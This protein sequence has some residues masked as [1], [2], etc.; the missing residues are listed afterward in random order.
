[1][2]LINIT[3]ERLHG[4]SY[5][6]SH[7]LQVFD[8]EVH[9]NFEKLN[10]P[11]TWLRKNFR[12][13]HDKGKEEWRDFFST[14]C[15]LLWQRRNARI[16]ENVIT[17]NETI[18]FKE[19]SILSSLSKARSFLKGVNFNNNIVQPIFVAWAPPRHG[20]VK[21]NVDGACSHNHVG[22]CGGVLRDDQCALK[23]AEIPWSSLNP[24]VFAL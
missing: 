5:Q 1:M 17:S 18:R 19:D 6:Y 24:L 14:V 7:E 15:W 16:F 11:E 4:I 3:G 12:I 20:W 22:A 9:W 10:I 2:F 21:M 8:I 23:E 13:V